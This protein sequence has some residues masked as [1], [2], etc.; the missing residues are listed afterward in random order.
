MAIVISA[1]VK[2]GVWASKVYITGQVSRSRNAGSEACAF[3][4]LLSVFSMCVWVH[5]SNQIVPVV[6]AVD[7]GMPCELQVFSRFV[8]CL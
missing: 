3:V 7:L 6:I 2:K 4:T 8:I 1:V 5:F